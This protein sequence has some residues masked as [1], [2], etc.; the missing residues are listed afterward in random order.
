[1]STMFLVTNPYSHREMTKQTLSQ[2]WWIEN[3]PSENIVCWLHQKLQHAG[4]K[5]MW[6]AAKARG[7][8][9]QLSD[10]VQACWDCDACSKMRLR[11][12]PK[13]AAHLARGHNPLQQWQ[14]D[15]IGPLPQSEGV[16]YS[17][18]C[19]NTTS[20]L[21]QAYPVPWVSQAYTIKALTELMSASGTLQVI[22]SDQ[23]THF[24]GAVIQCWA[25][26]NNIEWRFHL[27]YNPM[28]ASLSEPPPYTN[29]HSS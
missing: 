14:V 19:I 9:R 15:F 29:H 3:S 13:T 17:L 26:E 7:L 5:T 24:T 18:T 16:R 25:E 4:Q 1:M 20:R 28:G 27:P 2:V 6:A 12:L 21:M 11:S 22:E 10:I 8:P 23:G